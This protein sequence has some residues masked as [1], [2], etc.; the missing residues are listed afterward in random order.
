MRTAA[1]ALVPF[2]AHAAAPSRF[3]SASAQPY[4]SHPITVIVPF[5]AGGP[6]DVV[7]R[8]VTEQMGR[9]LGQTSGDR[10][11]RGGRRHHRLCARRDG[12]ARWLHAARRFHGLARL[13]ARLTPN[14]KY[15][16]GRDFEPIGFTAHAPAVHRRAQGFPVE[17]PSEFVAYPNRTAEAV[18][19]AHGGIG[20]S[21][22][23]ACVM[24]SARDRRET[25]RGPL[26]RHRTRD[27]RLD[28]RPRR[29][30]L[31]TGGERGRARSPPGAIKAYAFF[32]AAQRLAALPDVPTAKELGVQSRC[33]VGRIVSEAI[34]LVC[35]GLA[36]SFV[37]CEAA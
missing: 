7:A 35:P 28:R 14:V 2:C 8:I 12:R 17:G 23:M 5:P 4:P 32:F 16:S 1:P 30:F 25:N 3:L 34:W 24:F 18:K 11:C 33:E 15:D 29:L 31:R 22:H 36:D 27:E 20:A 37:G 19:Q 9:Q 6:S 10:E 13:R 26:S 21:S